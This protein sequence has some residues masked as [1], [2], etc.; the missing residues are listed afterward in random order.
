VT[1]V[2][3]ARA[4]HVLAVVIWIGGVAFVT[5]IALPVVRRGDFGADRV[6]AFRAIERRFVW[7]ARTAIVVVGATGFY[8][9][10]Q[11]DL[12]MRFASAE[13]WWVDA[14][15][16]LWSLFA[17]ILFLIEPF[18]LHRYLHRLASSAPDRFFGRLQRAHW[19]L[20]TLGLITILGAVA[21]SH[22]LSW[23]G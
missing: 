5:L 9:A 15:V 7:Y 10:A 4:L 17:I 2:I 11:G 20:L 12:W 23:F 22:G 19:I 16:G 3:A 6:R 13:F 21:G 14:M 8:M 18:I 1:A